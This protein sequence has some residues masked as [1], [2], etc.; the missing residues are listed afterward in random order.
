MSQT[1][2]VARVGKP[3][4][5]RGEVTVQVHTDDP[6]GRLT[7]GARFATDPQQRGPLTLVSVRQHQ[8]TFL[9]GFEGHPDRTAAEALRGTRLLVDDDA[10][11]EEDD[12]DAGW[13]ED[14]LLGFAVVQVDGRPVGEVTA[15]HLRPVQDL[16]EVR[17]PSGGVVLVPFVEELV[18]QVDEEARTVVVDPPPGLL[19]LGE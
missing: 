19:E 4:G 3:H 17:T 9:L 13:R 8:G 7:P 1:F 2:V 18:P 16:L 5:L 14:D 12:D 15:L 11:G 10:D 6:E